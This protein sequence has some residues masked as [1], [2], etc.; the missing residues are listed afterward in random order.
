M[1]SDYCRDACLLRSLFH[2]DDQITR[3][4]HLLCIFLIEQM[5]DRAS[6]LS[7]L[8]TLFRLVL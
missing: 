5:Q 4:I 7:Y 6:L 1:I 3:L 8:V 2:V